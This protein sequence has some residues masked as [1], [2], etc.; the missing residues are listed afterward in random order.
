[1]PQPSNQLVTDIV[2]TY[3]DEYKGLNPILKQIEILSEFSGF[4]PTPASRLAEDLSGSSFN[5]GAEGLII[6]LSVPKI[7]ERYGVFDPA[8]QYC[9]ALDFVLRRMER[10]FF[11]NRGLINPDHLRVDPRVER[12]LNSSIEKQVGAILICPGQLGAKYAGDSP[13]SARRKFGKFEFGFR[14]FDGAVSSIANPGRFGQYRELE[15]DCPGTMFRRDDSADFFWTPAYRLDMRNVLVRCA[16]WGDD[17]S[18]SYGSA[19]WFI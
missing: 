3:P 5:L 9:C 15:M 14:D 1:M 10:P 17:S 18:P 11:D 4:D 8:W 12:A 6:T 16:R 2:R 19:T 7:A 13:A